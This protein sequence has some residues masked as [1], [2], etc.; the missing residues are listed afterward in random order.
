MWLI[1]LWAVLIPLIIFGDTHM[2]PAWAKIFFPIGFFALCVLAGWWLESVVV[3]RPA[4]RADGTPYTRG[5]GVSNT[6]SLIVFILLAA[7]FLVILVLR[8][9]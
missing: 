2:W 6:T 9:V 1:L 8:L 4:E 3:R 5:E 7:A